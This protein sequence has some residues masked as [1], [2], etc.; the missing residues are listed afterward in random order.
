MIAEWGQGGF[1]LDDVSLSAVHIFL[2]W[3][4]WSDLVYYKGLF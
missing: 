3:I 2:F 1:V 4:S